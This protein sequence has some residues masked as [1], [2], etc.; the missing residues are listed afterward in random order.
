MSKLRYT[1]LLKSYI[2]KKTVQ[3]PKNAT[4]LTNTVEL[5]I[6]LHFIES[7]FTSYYMIVSF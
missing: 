3:N 1:K 5:F 6:I 2:F 4:V 7:F